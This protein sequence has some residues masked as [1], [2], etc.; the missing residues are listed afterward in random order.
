MSGRNTSR[1][2]AGA[3]ARRPRTPARDLYASHV[4]FAASHSKSIELGVFVSIWHRQ[5]ANVLA[6]AIARVLVEVALRVFEA[7]NSKPA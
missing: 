2:D 5:C 1:T 6:P 3:R 4:H 7:G